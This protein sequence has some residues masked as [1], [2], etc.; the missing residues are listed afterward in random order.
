MYI[1]TLHKQVLVPRLTG[2]LEHHQFVSDED[3]GLS[4]GEN[5]IVAIV[6]DVVKI[7]IITALNK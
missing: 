1:F 7:Q 4:M 5:A 3:F 2:F 6:D